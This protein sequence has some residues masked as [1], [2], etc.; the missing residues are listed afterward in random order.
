MKILLALVALI[1]PGLAP[2]ASDAEEAADDEVDRVIQSSRVFVPARPTV[3][4][5]PKYPAAELRQNN[6]AWVHVAYCIDEEGSPQNIRVLESVGDRRFDEAAIN[7]VRRWK[8]RPATVDGEPTWQS[9]NQSYLTFM[10]EDLESVATPRFARQFT[11]LG[12]L[13]DDGN[14]DEADRFFWRVHNAGN[15]RLYEISKLWSQRVRLDAKTGDLYKLDMALHRATWSRGDWID[16]ESYAELLAF[17]V[18]VEL[19]LGKYAAARRSFQ[20]LVRLTGRDSEFVTALE[21]LMIRLTELIGSGNTIMINGEVRR[22][23]EC[24]GC[25]DSWTFLPVRPSF[26]LDNIQGS[27]D[28]IEMRCDHKRFA[29]AVSDEVEWN[30]PESWGACFVYLFGTPGTTFD[31]YMPPTS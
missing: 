19:K 10:I 7:A 3:R 8:F 11:R 30:I 17:R 20:E 23:D 5:A 1:C 6:E 26:S 31:V 15:L 28:S 27:I 16:D 13:I 24:F 29:S 18:Q 25:D 2:L 22:R 4:V 9:R 21:P 14:L 12:K